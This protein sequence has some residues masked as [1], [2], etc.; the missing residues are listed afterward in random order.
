[1]GVPFCLKTE[2]AAN[3]SIKTLH[4]ATSLHGFLNF[5]RT[6][7]SFSPL[8]FTYEDSKKTHKSKIAGGV[9]VKKISA[10]NIFKT[11]IPRLM[12]RRRQ[13]FPNERFRGCRQGFDITKKHC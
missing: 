9:N 8:S 12:K 1:M 4:G 6:K 13:N 2:S 5:R 10:K 3:F 11:H 7:F